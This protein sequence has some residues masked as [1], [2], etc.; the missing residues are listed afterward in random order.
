MRARSLFNKERFR[1]KSINLLKEEVIQGEFM[2]MQK[3]RERG[4][5]TS[6]VRGAGFAT[7]LTAATLAPLKRAESQ[8]VYPYPL[9]QVCVN[10]YGYGLAIIDQYGRLYPCPIY[11]YWAPSPLGY[12]GGYGRGPWIGGSNR[13]YVGGG[14]YG[15][16]GGHPKGEGG[17]RR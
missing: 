14:N 7:A 13:G 17:R 12:L 15:Y 16:S 3:T 5:L 9:P 2:E 10:V 4:A 1:Y 6:I 8:Y 11:Y